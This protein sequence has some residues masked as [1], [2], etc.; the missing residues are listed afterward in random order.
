M[1]QSCDIIN[2]PEKVPAYVKIDSVI[3]SDAIRSMGI[4]DVWINIDGNAAG[5]F[6]I[7]AFF[8]LIAETGEEIQIRAGIKSNGMVEDRIIYPFYTMHVESPEFIEGETVSITPVFDYFEETVIYGQDFEGFGDLSHF[9]LEATSSSDT[10]LIITAQN[11]IYGGK[12]GAI[13]LEGD[14][15]KYF[16][17]FSADFNLEK[18][19]S[20]VFMEIDYKCNNDFNVG[21]YAN[22][23][24][25]TNQISVMTIFKSEKW[26]KIYIEMT[27]ILQSNQNANSFGF[28]IEANKS[29]EVEKAEIYLDNIKLIKF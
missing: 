23:T 5:V 15:K 29:Y 13:F 7:P 22:H 9:Y 11:A 1:L 21:L 8:P 6:E 10:S 18:N 14:V 25:V 12:C 26:N 2:P 3:I 20:P 17:R 16:G 24:V 28:F 27:G 4:V 19:G